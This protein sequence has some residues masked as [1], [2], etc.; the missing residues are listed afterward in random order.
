MTYSTQSFYRYASFTSAAAGISMLLMLCVMSVFP[1]SLTLRFEQV[2]DVQTYTRL[3]LLAEAPLR[4]VQTIDHLFLIFAAV[5]FL[6]VVTLVR[7]ETNKPMVYAAIVPI[8][9]TVY[10]DMYENHHIISML[11]AVKQGLPITADEIRMQ[12]VLSLVKFHGGNLNYFLL[13]FF[14]PHQ[15]TLEKHF[16]FAL[17]FLLLPFSVLR[18]SYGDVLEPSVYSFFPIAAGFLIVSAIFYKRSQQS[19]K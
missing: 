15:T 14:F 1:Q 4:I 17:L 11:A 5:T 13:A 7:N 9:L 3:L 19:E 16:R 12:S 10:L 18:Y 2:T 6:F 8:L